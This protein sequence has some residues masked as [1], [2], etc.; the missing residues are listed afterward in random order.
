MPARPRPEPAGED[1]A[2]RDQEHMLLPRQMWQLSSTSIAE[3]RVN[4]MLYS[5]SVIKIV[6]FHRKRVL[7]A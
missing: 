5:L 1:G 7:R 6:T 2:T 4:D 3:R